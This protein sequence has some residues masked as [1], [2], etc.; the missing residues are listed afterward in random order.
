MA[1]LD[2]GRTFSRTAGLVRGS[3]GSVGVFLLAVQV[4]SGVVNYFLKG[5]LATNM[6]GLAGNPRAGLMLFQSGSYWL[7]MGFSLLVGAFAM[8][9]AVSGMLRIARG[10]AATVG[11]CFGAAMAKALPMLGLTVLWMLGLWL[12]FILILVP[13]LIVLAMW[14]V[15]APVLVDEGSGV[16]A[17]FGRSRALTKGSRWKILLVLLIVTMVV[18]GGGA[19]VLGLFGMSMKDFGATSYAM[20]TL[21]MTLGTAI[22]GMLFSMVVD[23][24]LCAFYLELHDGSGGQLA[25]VFA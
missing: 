25:E 4:V 19:L 18:Y 3:L 9:G 12:G 14:C 21:G 2:I 7:M 13:G 11:D 20:P 24:L 23:A 22:F 1:G 15:A 16:V 17:A 6:A 8:A 10:D 5:Q